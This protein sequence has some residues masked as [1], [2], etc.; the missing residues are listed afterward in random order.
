V[1]APLAHEVE[2]VVEGL[3]F[4]MRREQ[5]AWWTAEVALEPGARYGFSV[6]SGPIRPDPRSPSQ[7]D[8]VEGL[9]QFWVPP[10]RLTSSWH[11]LEIGAGSIYELHVGTFSNEGTFD[12]IVS[13]LDHLKRLGVAAIELMPVASYPGRW[14][15]GYDGVD[16]FAPQAAYGGP[17]GLRRLIAACHDAG[18]G[19][20]LD[21]VY[22][23]LGPSGN[24]L[25]YFGPYFTDAYR[26]PWGKALN[27][28]REWSEGA[29]ELVIDN[30]QMWFFDYDVDGLRL[31][32][33]H[34]VYDFS[35]WH[36]IEE[37]SERRAAWEEE[38]GKRLWIFA[39]DD[40]ND[41]RVVAPRSAGGFGLDAVWSDDFHHALHAALTGE[42][43]HYYSDYQGTVALASALKRGYVFEG[44]Y[45]AF[46]RR[47]H[48]R[49]GAPPS[50]ASLV[51][52]IQN[53]D[54]VGNRPGG[55]RLS[56]LVGPEL[57]KVG[58]ALL[59]SSPFI[60][61]LFQG[62]EW[63][64]SSRFY[65][66]CDHEAE[67]GKAISEARKHEALNWGAATY[68]DPQDPA[69]F[70]ASRLRWDEADTSPHRQVALWYETLAQLRP[71]LLEL[72]SQ[73]EASV[74][75]EGSL[76]T[77]RRGRLFLVANFGDRPTKTKFPAD[78]LASSRE[79]EGYPGGEVVIQEAS[80][81]VGAE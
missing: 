62:E 35:A 12:G 31:D 44:Q 40:R 10:P 33:L 54:Q 29:R 34:A 60:P 69:T 22:N 58:A 65:Y 79:P 46:R 49:P 13:H 51:C 67:L 11:G 71:V 21:V 5:G 23:H 66:F 4:P 52:C 26:T 64:A 74:S 39:E 43:T 18:I 50:P 42:T 28:D 47:R 25:E 36:V 14:G 77:L 73:E 68:K 80:V 59:L 38:L 76:L 37:L 6:N 7:P 30:A 16:L 2:L 45:S 75:V 15:W 72:A 20:I 63:A 17:D 1:W 8:G 41:W 57:A 19:V 27:F 55:E 53:H 70:E 32:A 61:L 81:L 48:G 9:S 78:V 56:H 24:Y 3:R